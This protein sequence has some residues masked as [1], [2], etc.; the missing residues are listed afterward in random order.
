M[1]GNMV[2][3]G[4]GAAGP[5]GL[6]VLG[7]TLAQIT[8]IFGAG[9]AGLSMRSIPPGWTPR[10]TAV[11]AISVV[12]VATT[13]L[14]IALTT[15]DSP[16]AVVAAS[17]TACAMGMQAAVARKVGVADV[18]TV[19]V[20]STI[21]VWATDMFARP[22]RATILN[23][24]IAAIVAILLGALVGAVLVQVALWLVFKVVP[25]SELS[26][27]LLVIVRRFGRRVPSDCDLDD[28]GWPR[29][30]DARAL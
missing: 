22:S 27:S 21:I 30:Q 3:L 18:M 2:I 17:M 15:A 1:T 26:S 7:P 16:A 14:L 25:G 28:I 5:D 9:I 8:F 11:A 10:L 13:A 29:P 24:R 20:T 12:I 19:V 6:P 4:M 23:R